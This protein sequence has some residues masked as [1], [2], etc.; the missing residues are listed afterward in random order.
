MVGLRT[1]IFIV[2]IVFVL[3]SCTL[4]PPHRNEL[5]IDLKAE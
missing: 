5:S 1:S 2:D 4:I 3:I